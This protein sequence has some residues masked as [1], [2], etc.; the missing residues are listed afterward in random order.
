M[1]KLMLNIIWENKM[2]YNCKECNF[3][4]EGTVDTFDKVREHEKTHSVNIRSKS[5]RIKIK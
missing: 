1:K 3:Q 2:K 5:M 4:W